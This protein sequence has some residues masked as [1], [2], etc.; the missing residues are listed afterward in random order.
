[1]RG[2]R[3]EMWEMR[4]EGDVG[5]W[6]RCGEMWGGMWGDGPRFAEVRRGPPRSAEIR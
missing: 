5:R 3:G 4:R 1:M 2:R 6:G